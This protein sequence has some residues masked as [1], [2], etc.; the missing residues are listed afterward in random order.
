MGKFGLNVEAA[1][2]AAMFGEGFS[3]HPGKELRLMSRLVEGPSTGL[4][5]RR[6]LENTEGCSV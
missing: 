4:D 2:P 5:M 1:Y 6:D 3:L